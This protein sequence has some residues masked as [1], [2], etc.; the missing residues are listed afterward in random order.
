MIHQSRIEDI[1]D[2]LLDTLDKMPNFRNL[3]QTEWDIRV[4]LTAALLAV[5]VELANRAASEPQRSDNA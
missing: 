2:V 3:T 4:Q 5:E 1:R